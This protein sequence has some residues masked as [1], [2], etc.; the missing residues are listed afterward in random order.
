MKII[1][2]VA[3]LVVVFGAIR[4]QAENRATTSPVKWDS[5]PAS[6]LAKI[7]GGRGLGDFLDEEPMGDS[8]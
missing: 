8:H 2:I 7:P 1:I 6:V 3:L 4:Q 5:S